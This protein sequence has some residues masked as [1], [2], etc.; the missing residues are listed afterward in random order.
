MLFLH[1]SSIPFLGF[2]S[3]THLSHKILLLTPTFSPKLLQYTLLCSTHQLSH[4]SSFPSHLLNSHLVNKLHTYSSDAS[5]YCMHL[6]SAISVLHVS[7]L[8]SALSTTTSYNLFFTFIPIPLKLSLFFPT[9]FLHHYSWT[10]PAEG[11]Y[12]VWYEKSGRWS[13]KVRV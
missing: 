9:P 2:L 11:R 7:A 13:E 3:T 6:F 5:P 8:N 10:P 1:C 4:N 12:E